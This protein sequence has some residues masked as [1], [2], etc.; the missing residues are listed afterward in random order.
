EHSVDPAYRAGGNCRFVFNDA[1]LAE[2]RKLKDEEGRPLWLP[3]PVPGM[4]ATINGNPYTID[5]SM[6]TVSASGTGVSVLFGDFRAG[7]VVRQSLDV[8]MVRLAERYADF[9]QVGFFG[10]ARLD[11]VPDDASAVRGLYLG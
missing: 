7:Y 1:T 11:A 9:L 4:P 3:V 8:Q 6:P 5:Q 2:L 10:F